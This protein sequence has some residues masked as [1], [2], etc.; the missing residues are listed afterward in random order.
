[1]KFTTTLALAASAALASAQVTFNQTTGTFTC[2]A[3]NQVYC[4]GDSGTTNIIIRCDENAVGHPGNCNDNLSGE[5]PFGVN[6]APCYAP[7]TGQAACSKN[8]IVY[9]G[10]GNING[11]FPIPDCVPAYT[12][13]TSAAP[14]TTYGNNT[15]T[16]SPTTTPVTTITYSYTT[17]TVPCNS[18]SSY[19]T[20]P[21]S[22]SGSVGPVSNNTATYPGGGS[23]T[24]GGASG[25]GSATATPVGP[26]KTGPAVVGVNAAVANGAGPL[27]ALAGFLAAALL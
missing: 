9:G 23:A 11:T 17:I 21:A 14:T 3:P 8:C 13:T 6:T 27:L 24:S 1:M 16:G 4:A 19:P 26:T 2:A 22:G 5:F 15:A 7:S 18:T 12:Q 25:S 20:A 10:S